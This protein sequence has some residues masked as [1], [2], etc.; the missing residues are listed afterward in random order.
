M[1]EGAAQVLTYEE[2]EVGRKA[3]LA[4]RLTSETI[5]AFA[6]LTGDFN[7]LHVSGEFARSRAITR[8]RF[9]IP[10]KVSMFGRGEKAIGQLSQLVRL[11]WGRS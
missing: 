5:D 4:V 10:L 8:E 3:R 6:A 7:P 1:S 2:I 9:A 11:R